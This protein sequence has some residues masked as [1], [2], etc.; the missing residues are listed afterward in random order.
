MGRQIYLCANHGVGM[1]YV[2]TISYD[3]S[4][5]YG[6]QRQKD[7]I[8]IQ[9]ELEKALHTILQEDIQIVASGRTDAGVHALGQVVHFDTTKAIEDNGKFVYSLNSML[10]KSID[11][12]D[13]KKVDDSFHARYSVHEKT[14][15]YKIYL[16]K[17]NEPLKRKYYHICSYDLDVEKMKEAIK[18]IVGEHDFKAFCVENP[19]IKTTTRTIFDAHIDVLDGG[20]EIDIVL[21]ANGFLHNQVR[22]IAGTLVDIGRGR[23]NVEDMQK[24]L[25]SKNHQK[26]GKTLDGCGL[27][28][29]TVAYN[30]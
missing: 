18:V 14:Y 26:A 17:T 7:L 3:G 24:I 8:T 11:V 15:I 9:G 19:Q 27:Y 23:F 21:T 4:D 2:L 6:F 16:S 1:R 25:D 28:L 29:Y 10:P 30:N 20:K 22:S 12:L 5:F 13:M